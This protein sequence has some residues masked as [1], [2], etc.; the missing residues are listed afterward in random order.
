MGATPAPISLTWLLTRPGLT[1]SIIGPVGV[2]QLDGAVR[3]IDVL[4]DEKAL[5]Q[6]DAIFPGH[7]TAPEDY[8][9]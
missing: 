9:L 2:E 3:S 6:L 5:T 8:A 1:S 7:R 4:L